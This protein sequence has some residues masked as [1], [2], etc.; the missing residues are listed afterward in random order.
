MEGDEQLFLEDENCNHKL[1]SSPLNCPTPLLFA[2][3]KN[4]GK[5]LINLLILEIIQSVEEKRSYSA[6]NEEYDLMVIGSGPGGKAAAFAAAKIGKSVA[7]VDNMRQMGGSNVHWGTIP[8][9][10]IIYS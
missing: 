4:C 7:I 6:K 8:V 9:K 10:N 3:K 1:I 2:S 5:S